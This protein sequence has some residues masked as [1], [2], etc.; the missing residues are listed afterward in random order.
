MIKRPIVVVLVAGAS[1]PYRLPS[2]ADLRARICVATNEPNKNGLGRN[3]L[4]L[5]KV[6]ET[7]LG[8]FVVLV[9]HRYS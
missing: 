8:R 3:I 1:I 6:K 7:D 4:Q 2:G 9:V 5:G